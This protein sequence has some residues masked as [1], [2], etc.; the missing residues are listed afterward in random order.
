MAR[1]AEQCRAFRAAIQAIRLEGLSPLD[2]RIVHKDGETTI[3][4]AN[5][6]GPLDEADD[7]ERRMK[8]AFGA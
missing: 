7:M 4:P 2:F 8:D 1:V 3:L 5:A 6:A